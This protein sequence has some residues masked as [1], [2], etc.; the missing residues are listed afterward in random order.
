MDLGSILAGLALL[1]A[2]AFYVARPI[3]EGRGVRERQV[4]AA[5]RLAAERETV[6]G[7]LRDLDFD[8]ATGKITDEDYAP[9]RAAL[10]SQGVEILKQLEALAGPA[11]ARAAD[12]VERAAASRPGRGRSLD[13]Q[14]EA[15]VEARRGASARPA[16]FCPQ[17]GQPAKAGDKFC[18]KCGAELPATQVAA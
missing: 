9:Q 4:T 1:L 10:V 12:A 17:C 15:E 14:I 11:A 8:Q 5:D 16:G 13:E 18:A 3:L 6:L 2:V 7:A